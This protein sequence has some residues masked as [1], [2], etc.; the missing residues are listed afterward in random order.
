MTHRDEQEMRRRIKSTHIAESVLADLDFYHVAQPLR[1]TDSA[2]S[3]IQP[4]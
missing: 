2:R 4:R 1:S 3:S